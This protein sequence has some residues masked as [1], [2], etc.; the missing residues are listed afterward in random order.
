M[1]INVKSDSNLFIVINNLYFK[2]FK[3][4]LKDKD[5]KK[6]EIPILKVNGLIKGAVIPKGEYS[7]N[8]FYAPF[9]KSLTI[10]NLVYIL[11]LLPLVLVILFL[12][13]KFHKN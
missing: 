8:L 11:F 1:E 12:V 3:M 10:F 9:K 2:G 4:Y 6:I 13:K 7:V 5:G